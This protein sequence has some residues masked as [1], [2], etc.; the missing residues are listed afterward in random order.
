MKN[1]LIGG[2]ERILRAEI[3]VILLLIILV[4]EFW[5]L[6]YSIPPIIYR[7]F[8]FGFRIVDFLIAAV[9]LNVLIHRIV[10]GK[11]NLKFSTPITRPLLL[12]GI[13][14]LIGISFTALQG[15]ANFFFAWK[16]LF[17]GVL[18]FYSFINIFTL[19]S[20]LKKLFWVLFIVATI[21][22]AYGLILYFLGKGIMTSE[23]GYS[24]FMNPPIIDFFS[25][26]LVG[27]AS[28]IVLG[29]RKNKIP[30]LVISIAILFSAVLLSLKRIDWAILFIGLFVLFFLVRIKYKMRLIFF[31][32]FVI[33]FIIPFFYSGFLNLNALINRFGTVKFILNST[34]ATS[35]DPATTPSPVLHIL[36]I[37]DAVDVIK[38]NP[39]LGIGPGGSYE[40]FRIREWKKI[41][42][43]VHNGFLDTWL[44]FGI[45]GAIAYFW[46]FASFLYYGYKLF[47]RESVQAVSLH[48]GF[49]TVGVAIFVMSFL[50]A[51]SPF[52]SIQASI[53][54]FFYMAFS[55]S[56]I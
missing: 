53:L 41:S 22:S 20:Q 18:F 16:N 19:P 37:M 55:F 26:V 52:G 38:D 36:D 32:I 9:F 11:K 21:K 8:Q 47:C 15:S 45:L 4:D 39:I 2:A 28:F 3:Y 14:I 50:F 51:P 49:F 44:K 6:Q 31:G 33:I 13:A 24:T 48:L 30:L 56:R 27:G 54:L 35:S 25:A 12:F 42:Y 5:T 10:L 23:A 17:L 29:V 7:Q 1:I 46:I 34:S 43:G 40:T